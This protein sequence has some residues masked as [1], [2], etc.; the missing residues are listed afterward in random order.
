MSSDHASDDKESTKDA[1]TVTQPCTT[2]KELHT[3]EE[4]NNHI[5]DHHEPSISKKTLLYLYNANPDPTSL[6]NQIESLLDIKR[7]TNEQ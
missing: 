6:Q 2:S 1:L 7:N 3:E 4:N 5:H